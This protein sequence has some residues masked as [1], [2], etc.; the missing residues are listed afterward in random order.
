[1]LVFSAISVDFYDEHNTDGAAEVAKN[2]KFYNE[3][4]GS[5]TGLQ[6]INQLI[7]ELN[8]LIFN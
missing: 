3:V 1:M 5:S 6:L 7:N 4:I 8:E 2:K